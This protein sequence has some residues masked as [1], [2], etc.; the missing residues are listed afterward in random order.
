V[1]WTQNPV[2][3][4]VLLHL[5][6]KSTKQDL[7]RN[8]SS[9]KLYAPAR[10]AKRQR[11]QATNVNYLHFLL[12]QVNN[13]HWF[14]P[15]SSEQQ[16][17]NREKKVLDLCGRPIIDICARKTQLEPPNS[18]PDDL[19]DLDNQTIRLQHNERM[20]MRQTRTANTRNNA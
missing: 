4:R 16:N 15:C 7:A 5:C 1:P 9:K 14:P 10:A 2:A 8:S 13:K 19:D 18:D 11:A 17:G 12:V 6:P 20:N 3:E